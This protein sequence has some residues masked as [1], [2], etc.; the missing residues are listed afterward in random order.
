[1]AL[2]GSRH[3]SSAESGYAPV[4]GEALGVVWCLRKARLFLLGCPNLTLVTDHKPLVKLFGDKE[5]KDILNPRLLAMKEKT[6]IYN[7]NIKYLPG[8]KNPADFLSRYPALKANPDTA[9]EDLAAVIET[10]TIAA[11]VGTLYSECIALEE[12]EIQRIATGDP[13]Y[14][15][16]IAKVMS[17]DWRSSK[18]QAAT[19]LRPF[20]N[21]R[22][23]LSVSNNLVLYSYE[24]GPTRIVIPEALRAKI[25]ANLHAGHQG[26]DSMQRRARHTAYW[27]G[28]EGDLSYHRASCALC[29]ASAPSQPAEP[30]IMTPPPEYPFQKTTIDLC[31]MN[32]CN[33]LVYAD[34]LT[35][36]IE[37]AH[38]PGDSTSSKI[39]KH[40]RLYFTRYG[41]PV[42]VSMDGGTNL[43]SEEMT[44]FFKCWGGKDEN[45]ISTLPTVQR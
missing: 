23:R 3:L 9:D 25:A 20:Y 24:Q 27:P 8:K 10:A 5:L 33:Y 35:G 34:R 38:L 41:A 16:L 14:Q 4:E 21:V 39:I 12:E 1:M 26:L 36:W 28:M 7:F 6:L 13:V 2:C 40:L 31:Q 29:N 44:H 32:G 43:V 19:C 22:D 15:M 42:E 45:I 18:S 17:N 37:I 30:M 11:V